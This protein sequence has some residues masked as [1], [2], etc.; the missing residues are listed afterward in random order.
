MASVGIDSIK[1]EVGL[2]PTK[3][4]ALLGVAVTTKDEK[5]YDK[6]YDEVLNYL[7]ESYGMERERKVYKSADIASIIPSTTIDFIT[8]FFE[9]MASQIDKL[10]VFYTRYNSQ[11]IPLISVYGKSSHYTKIKPV[12]FIRKIAN[13]YPHVCVW[14]YITVYANSKNYNFY[15]DHFEA[16]QTPAWTTISQLPNI[17]VI[18]KGDKC[19]C[20]ISSA[21]FLLR[22]IEHR[23]ENMNQRLDTRGLRRIFKDFSW[24]NKVWVHCLGGQTR[25]LRNI[26]PHIKKPVDLEPYIAHPIV[27]VVH[28][29]PGGV[30]SV[31]EKEMF[32][33]LPIFSDLLNFLFFTHG[34]LKH[35]SPSKDIKLMQENDYL[36]VMGKNGEELFDYLTKGGLK[37]I[38]LTPD[39]LKTK[40]EKYIE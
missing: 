21:D 18:Y 8:S 29:A 19:N 14:W 17:K 5:I 36:L 23:I 6:N 40:L 15:I 20:L 25:I 32:E 2:R 12:D 34:S 31:E 11:K 35:F 16:E 26:S 30:K 28:E 27:F 7:F 22:M 13:G 10:D 33:Q 24:S 38:R 39:V 9:R 3:F 1:V 37:L 4:E